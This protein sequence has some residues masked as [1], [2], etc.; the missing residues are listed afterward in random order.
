MGKTSPVKSPKIGNSGNG[1][2]CFTFMESAYKVLEQFGNRKPMHYREVT[3]KAMEMG[4]LQT[5]GRTP[6]ATMSAQIT[7]DI[8]RQEKRGRSSRFILCGRGLIGLTEWKE[9]G[10]SHQIEQHNREIQKKLLSQVRAL[11]PIDFEQLIEK[12]LIKMGLEMVER[13]PPSNDGGI[14]V[15]GILVVGEVLRFK[16][17]IQVKR[18]AANVQSNTVREL[19]GSLSAHERGLIITTSDF[20]RGAKEEGE[21]TSAEPIALMNGQSLVAL[22]VEHE[23]GVHRSMKQLFEMGENE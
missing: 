20:S 4:W 10:L 1:G 9:Q 8:K 11:D 17:A 2:G 12:L 7:T 14:D 5:G 23:M 19:R 18:W 16:M 22:L 6:E 21:R 3:A 15:R 13:T